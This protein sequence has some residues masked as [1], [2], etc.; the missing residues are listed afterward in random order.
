MKKTTKTDAA[1]S[2]KAATPATPAPSPVTKTKAKSASAKTAKTSMSSSVA[3]ASTPPIPVETAVPAASESAPVPLST[4]IVAQVDVG[5]GNSLYIRGE[6]PGLSWEKGITL[7]CVAD[8]KWSIELE[9][10]TK[11]IV[12][13]FLLNDQTWC[14]GD[15]HV[16]QPGTT[17]T[18][19]PVF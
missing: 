6:G 4:T 7:E 13:K 19:S 8:D 14:K 2:A 5:F 3:T 11:P 1:K 18:V 17:V 9:E 15:D 10:T 12:Y 16:A